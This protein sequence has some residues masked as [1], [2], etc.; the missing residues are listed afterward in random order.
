MYAGGHIGNEGVRSRNAARFPY[1]G[2]QKASSYTEAR[3]SA[4]MYHSAKNGITSREEVA[5]ISLH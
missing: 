5:F 1:L 2:A 4:V 3:V